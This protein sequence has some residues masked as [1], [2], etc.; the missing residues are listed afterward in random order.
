MGVSENNCEELLLIIES[1]AGCLHVSEVELTESVPRPSLG[2]AAAVS[3]ASTA[4]VALVKSSDSQLDWREQ[5]L[6]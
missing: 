6:S 4:R 1:T 5:S 2:T 3:T